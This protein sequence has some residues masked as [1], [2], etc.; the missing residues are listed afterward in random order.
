MLGR[1]QN[2]SNCVVRSSSYSNWNDHAASDS[3]VRSRNS[4]LALTT[5]VTSRWDGDKSS[6]IL[7]YARYRHVIKWIPTIKRQSSYSFCQHQGQ[8]G[9]KMTINVTLSEQNWELF[10]CCEHGEG[11]VFINEVWQLTLFIIDNKLKLSWRKS[12]LAADF[13]G[14]MVPFEK[15]TDV[16]S[17]FGKIFEEEKKNELIFIVEKLHHRSSNKKIH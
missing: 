13:V 9:S 10:S 17:N 6:I 7:N 5:S 8:A 1:N 12:R 2:S 11:K 14:A 15:E 3:T 4:Y 16:K